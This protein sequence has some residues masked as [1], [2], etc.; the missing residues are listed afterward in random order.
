MWRR[1]KVPGAGQLVAECEAFLS[2]GY[3]ECLEDLGLAVPGW[4]WTNLLAHGTEDDIRRAGSLVGSSRPT[5][6]SKWREARS[7]LAGE[8]TG[9]LDAGCCGLR[10]L[11]G[12][13][14][15]PLELRLASGMVPDDRSPSRLAGTVLGA[16][17]Q[18][19]ARKRRPAHGPWSDAGLPNS[20]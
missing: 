2:G 11:Q 14:L 12:S 1:G 20:H 10:E 15:V 18:H 7:Y 5:A 6:A 13:V 3:A 19:Q 16:L 17:R 4:A 8:V 9:L